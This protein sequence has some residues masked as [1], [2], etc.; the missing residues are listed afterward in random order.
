[1]VEGTKDAAR[2][3]VSA[4]REMLHSRPADGD[5]GELG[6]YEEPIRGDQHKDRR[7]G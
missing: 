1:V 5:Q 3:S 2:A 6:G 4:G 7:Q